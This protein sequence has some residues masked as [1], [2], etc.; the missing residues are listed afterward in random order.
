MKPQYTVWTLPRRKPSMLKRILAYTLGVGAL[1]VSATVLAVTMS[2][3][4]LAPCI[5]GV[6][7]GVVSMAYGLGE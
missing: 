2:P 5:L 7:F 4:M 1:L 3:A 6:A